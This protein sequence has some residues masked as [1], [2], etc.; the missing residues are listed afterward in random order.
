VLGSI[1]TTNAQG[2]AR[3]K[4]VVYANEALLHCL[5]VRHSVFALVSEENEEPIILDRSSDAGKYV[6][7]FDPLDGSSN[8][9]VNV[10]V[11]TVFSIFRKVEG[12]QD[13][14]RRILLQTGR[15][16]VAAGYVLYGPSTVLVYTFGQGVYGFTLDPAI[17]AYLLSH[18]NM[19]MSRQG[20]YYSCNEANLSSFPRK[21]QRY[22]EKLRDGEI[23]RAYGSRYI[24]SL[25]ADFHRNPSSGRR[26]S[27]S[28][29]PAFG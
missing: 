26:F 19:T 3:E 24:G 14:T 15:A 1:G 22:L 9:D 12:E 5:G 8:L 10:N 27:L 11:G 18:E 25:A 28:P 20:M 7:V 16:E 6:I 21:Y 17:G 4:L 23:G 2:E 29:N 13:R